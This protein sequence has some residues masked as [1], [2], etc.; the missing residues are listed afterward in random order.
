[1]HVIQDVVYSS[2]RRQKKTHK[3]AKRGPLE[4]L[5]SAGGQERGLGIYS[6]PSFDKCDSL[7][8]LPSAFTKCLNSGDFV[9]LQK[10]LTS[11]VSRCCSLSLANMHMNLQTMVHAFEFINEVHPDNVLFVVETK[12]VENEIRAKMCYKYT[13]NRTLRLAAE[14]T[15]PNPVVHRACTGPRTDPILFVQYVNSL[16]VSERADAAHMLTYAEEVVMYGDADMTITFD[17]HSK[18]VTA[19]KLECGFTSLKAH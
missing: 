7:L 14:K 15:F 10:L 18:K 19:L 6:F 2:Q 16:P 12:V 5:L 9:S 13:D 3:K 11:R 1:M 4:V 17:D 8:F